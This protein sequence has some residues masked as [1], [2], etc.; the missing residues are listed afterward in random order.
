MGI[1]MSGLMSGL[2]TESIVGA[3]MSAQSLKKT[4]VERSKT[5]LEWTQTKWA[6]LNTKLMKLYNEQVTK[7]QLQSSYK[8]KKAS[9]SDSSKV[10]VT[11]GSAAANGSYTLEI[12]NIATSQYLTG[13]KLDAKSVSKKLVDIDSD[14]LNKEISVTVGDKTTKFTVGADT[15]ISDFTK[16]L[17]DAGLNASYDTT[18]QRFSISSKDSGLANS[19]SITTSAL[20][21]AEVDGRKD[22]RDAV[23]YDNMTTANR[24]IVDGAI[25]TL[26]TSGVGTDEYNEALD[27]LSKAAYDTAYE[28]ATTYV[29]AKMYAEN[30][31]SYKTKAEEELKSTYYNED[32]SVKTEYAEKYGNDFDVLTQEDKDKIG[33]SGMSRDDYIKWAAEKEIA[34]KQDSV[35]KQADS[36]TTAFV[37]SQISTDENVKLDIKTAAY[38]G[39]TADDIRQLDPIALK[40]YYASAAD[41]ENPVI[42]SFV[43]TSEESIKNAASAY[44]GMTDARNSALTQSALT[45]LGLA[46]IT[47]A[48]D[49]KV[50]VN[51]GANNKDNTSIPKGMALVE[52]SDSKIILNGAELTSSTSTVSAFG[53]ELELTGLTKED[54][55][56]TFSVATDVDGVYDSIKTFLNEYN[57]IMKEMYSLYTADSAKGYEPLSSE[58]KKDMSDD[59]IKLW[60]DKIKGS[61]LRSDSTLNGIIQSMRSAM[62]SQVEYDGKTYS[63]ASFGIMTSTDYM[64]GGA[65]HIYGD[66]SDSVYADYDDKLKKAIADDPD[67]VMNVLSGIFSNLRDTMSK[68]MAGNQYSSALT[69]Y[70]DIKMKS[71]IKSYEKEIDEWED[72]L[73]EME[74]SY[75][76]KFTAM[77]KALAKLQS[78]QSSLGSL[79]GTN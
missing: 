12:E 68:K 52:A 61:L 17:R 77:E 74:D 62:M 58:Q 44:A 20:T 38:A 55:P 13:A 43:G 48:A 27:A 69:F 36:E 34:D 56:I 26:Q 75:Y 73:A 24:A 31:G 7:M 35:E 50:S 45:G 9:V 49:G 10:K 22:I 6:D 21:T 59:D 33:V 53:L 54:E 42:K 66:K 11:A 16:A 18:Q 5:K 32:G 30:Y 71:D 65:L 41:P 57:S 46:D 28:S 1:R 2:D 67:A 60:E 51:G 79:F 3:L 40:K 47:V 14:L 8:T 72:R 78:Q 64:E 63:L 23:G 39:K 76:S 4:R 15:T 29:K 70:N 37:N 25:E 19:F